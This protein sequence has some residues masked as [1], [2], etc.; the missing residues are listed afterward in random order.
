MVFVGLKELILISTC[1][2]SHASTDVYIYTIGRYNV[3][4]YIT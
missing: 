3:Y 2:G 4:F 1:K